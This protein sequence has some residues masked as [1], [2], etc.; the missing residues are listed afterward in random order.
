MLAVCGVIW[1]LE[2]NGQDN[3]DFLISQPCS[4]IYP[5]WRGRHNSYAT[6]GLSFEVEGRHSYGTFLVSDLRTHQY[7][8]GYLRMYLILCKS[9]LCTWLQDNDN[10]AEPFVQYSLQ[11]WG[12]TDKGGL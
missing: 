9:A 1:Y 3:Q 4:E 10:P 7:L 12:H 2:V 11:H 5:A 6:W 8:Q